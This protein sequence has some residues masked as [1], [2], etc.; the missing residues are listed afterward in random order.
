MRKGIRSILWLLAVAIF[1]AA[2]LFVIDQWQREYVVEEG[3]VNTT[4][5]ATVMLIAYA[6]EL[7]V[8]R[9]LD[10]LTKVG[11]DDYLIPYEIEVPSTR[12]KSVIHALAL[13]NSPDGYHNPLKEKGIDVVDVQEQGRSTIII[14]LEGQPQFGG[15]C[16]TPRL[17][18]QIEETVRLI[19]KE[20]FEIRLNGS[21]EEYQCMGDASGRCGGRE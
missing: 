18:A 13:F 11:C 15:L 7:S 12:I 17:K 4:P 2:L 9:N 16:D 3:N 1:S 5:R 6:D 10:D 8:D 21:L 20:K 19:T 14:E